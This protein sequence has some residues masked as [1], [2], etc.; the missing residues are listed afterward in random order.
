MR[1]IIV[2]HTLLLLA[3]IES[4][5][6]IFIGTKPTTNPVLLEVKSNNRGVLIPRINIPDTL[7]ASPVSN[8]QEGLFVIN[9]HPG[10]EGLYFWNGQAWEKL[11]TEESAT[12]DLLQIGKQNQLVAIQAQTNMELA[13]NKFTNVPLSASLGKLSNDRYVIQETGVYEVTASFTGK[14]NSANG[15]FILNIHDYKNNK[16]LA[17][18]TGNQDQAYASI[19]AKAIYCGSLSKDT[20]IGIRIFFAPAATTTAKELLETAVLSVKKILSN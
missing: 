19:A 4:Y 12:A 11:K 14:P 7:K 18:T 17:Y 6:Q 8:P 1:K 16:A 15:Y 2:I 13:H 20:E 3:I 5:G 9:T 10:K